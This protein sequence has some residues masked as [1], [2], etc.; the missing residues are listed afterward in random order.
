[1]A[2]QSYY[3]AITRSTTE[4]YGGMAIVVPKSTATNFVIK[5]YGLLNPC[6]KQIP[7]NSD[8]GGNFLDKMPRECLKIT[9]EQV[10]SWT[11]TKQGHCFQS[12]SSSSNPQIPSD[13]A[14][15]KDMVEH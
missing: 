10:Q 15:L 3:G 2:D 8:A 11:I 7:L 9:D 14:E 4:G 5:S 12:N 6:S 13:V 1:M